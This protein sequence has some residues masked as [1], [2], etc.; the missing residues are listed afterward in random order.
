MKVATIQFAPFYRRKRENL[1]RLVGLIKEAAR[2]GAKLIVMPELAL[3][4]YSMMSVGE[5]AME[6]EVIC[7]EAPTMRLMLGLAAHLDVRLVWGMVERDPGTD[8]LY[9]SQVYVD[10]KGYFESYR[11]VNGFG[12][13]WSWATMGEANPPVIKDDLFGKVGLLICRDVRD[14]KDEKWNSFYE[15]GD[16]DLVCFSSA[17]GKGGIP[18]TAWMDFVRNNRTTLIVSNRYGTEA[19]NDFGAGG[20]CIIKP[21]GDDEHPNGVYIDGLIWGSDCIVYAEV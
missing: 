7:K 20:V 1:T 8:K 10:P 6:A 19:N 3:S 4:G 5:A 14:K 15:K 11:K 16:S 2:E 9:N 13:D 12:Q 17:W 18:A 21:D